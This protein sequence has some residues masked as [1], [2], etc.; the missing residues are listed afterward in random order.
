MR[1]PCPWFLLRRVS[2]EQTRHGTPTH[3]RNA[4][5][6]ELF[7]PGFWPAATLGG[8]SVCSGAALPERCQQS[9]PDSRFADRLLTVLAIVAEQ[10]TP[11]RRRR[12]PEWRG[13]RAGPGGSMVEVHDPTGKRES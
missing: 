9:V 7:A 3:R 5:D 12:L 8:R 2:P 4:E 13:D 6:A 10:V 11:W 1:S